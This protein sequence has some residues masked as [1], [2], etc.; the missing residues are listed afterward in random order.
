MAQHLDAARGRMGRSDLIDQDRTWHP[1]RKGIRWAGRP[2]PRRQAAEGCHVSR[3]RAVP[4]VSAGVVAALRQ[5]W[6]SRAAPGLRVLLDLA[7]A[8]TDLSRAWFSGLRAWS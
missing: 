8:I 4:R 3:G 6:R 2:F 1:L 5:G 7:R